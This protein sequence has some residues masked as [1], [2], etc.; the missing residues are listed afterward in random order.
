MQDFSERFA[1]VFRR[2]ICSW[3]DE[4]IMEV[5]VIQGIYPEN[6]SHPKFP[7]SKE[8]E[9]RKC[10][11]SRTSTRIRVTYKETFIRTL[12]EQE[13]FDEN[14]LV[15]AF[16]HTLAGLGLGNL[17]HNINIEDKGFSVW[18]VHCAA[19]YRYLPPIEDWDAKIE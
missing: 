11:E 5:E 10:W 19:I 7:E 9:L 16:A 1:Q 18:A 14:P 2:I 17:C 15:R 8:E 12:T 6:G 13:L 3:R 4:A